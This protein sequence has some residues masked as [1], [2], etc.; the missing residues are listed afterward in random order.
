MCVCEESVSRRDTKSQPRKADSNSPY[1]KS[2]ARKLPLLTPRPRLTLLRR[3][4]M[5]LNLNRQTR[6]IMRIP[7]TPIIADSVSEDGTVVVESRSC[8]AAADFWVTFE[9]VLGVLV[10]E[11]ECA[12][13][14]C[15]AE[16]AVDGVEGYGVYGIDF[17]HVAVCGVLLAVAFE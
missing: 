8:D 7:L 12:V 9:S 16:G 4:K 13:G 14:A 10:P 6:C 11:V 15:G 1:L 5:K 3:N 17:G 2:S